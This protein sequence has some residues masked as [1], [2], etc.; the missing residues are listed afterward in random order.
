MSISEDETPVFQEGPID[1]LH[2]AAW[3]VIANAGGWMDSDVASPGWK[4]AAERWRDEY[5][6]RLGAQCRRQL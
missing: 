4:E 3:V 2:E 6:F 1:D 5:L